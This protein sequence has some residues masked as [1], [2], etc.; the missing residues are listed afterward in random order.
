GLVTGPVWAGFTRIGMPMLLY[1]LFPSEARLRAS[2]RYLLTTD[3]EDWV[4]YLG[5][6]FRSFNLDM[7]VPALVQPGE[8]RDLTAPTLVLGAD[9]DLRFPGRALPRRGSQLFRSP[10]EEELIPECRHCPP[11]TDEFRHWLSARITRFLG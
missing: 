4:P 6:A 1:R 3:D 9:Q 11:T 10:L 7:R 5:D 2:L 8:L